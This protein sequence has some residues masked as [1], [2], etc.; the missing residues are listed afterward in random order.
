MTVEERANELALTFLEDFD[1]SAIQ[2]Q[3]YQGLK[4][5][6]AQAITEAVAEEREKDGKLLDAL[7]EKGPDRPSAV[8]HGW[9]QAWRSG[10][11][12]AAAAIREVKP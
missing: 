1:D 10:V 7:Y 9:G 12:D 11:L 2:Q 5:R 3:R 6:V 8:S 4:H